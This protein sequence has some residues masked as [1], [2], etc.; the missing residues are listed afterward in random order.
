MLP[1]G[2]RDPVAGVFVNTSERLRPWA[3][4]APRVAKREW[5][6]LDHGAELSSQRAERP[7][8]GFFTE[9]DRV[10]EEADRCRLQEVPAVDASERHRPGG[11]RP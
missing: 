3:I 7:V 5:L 2:S 6:G 10:A 8:L 1:I 11:V 9:H 4:K